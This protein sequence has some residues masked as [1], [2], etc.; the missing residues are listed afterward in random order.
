[1]PFPEENATHR[2]S[3]SNRCVSGSFSTHLWLLFVTCK[4]SPTSL[5]FFLSLFSL[6]SPAHPHPPSPF[7]GSLW[8]SRASPTMASA[9]TL[10]RLKLGEQSTL[11]RC[12]P[13]TTLSLTTGKGCVRYA[14]S[15][16]SGSY[17]LSRSLSLFC[18]F[19]R[20]LTVLTIFV[21]SQVLIGSKRGSRCKSS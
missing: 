17:S 10:A 1:M 12:L 2:S 13:C 8:T 21:T 20:V 3:L 9:L 11:L 18:F 5:S 14:L 19:I 16:W 15:L 4:H 7:R 6:S